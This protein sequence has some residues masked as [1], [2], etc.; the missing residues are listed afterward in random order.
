MPNGIIIITVISWAEL[1]S[2]RQPKNLDVIFVIRF[3]SNTFS[4]FFL[5][6]LAFR[7]IF[8]LVI[9]YWRFCWG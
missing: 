1:I 8:L 3:T 5:L 7:I 4:L 6:L 9:G 2:A